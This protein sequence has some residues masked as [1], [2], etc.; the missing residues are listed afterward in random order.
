MSPNWY[1]LVFL[2]NGLNQLAKR[3]PAPPPLPLALLIL[4]VFLVM[5][6][7]HIRWCILICLARGKSVVA[8]IFLIFPL[9]YPLAFIYLAFSSAD[10]EKGKAPVLSSQRESE[11]LLA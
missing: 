5:L 7:V 8:M 4:F 6:I 11:P 9:T 1:I 2:V 3:Y 10:T